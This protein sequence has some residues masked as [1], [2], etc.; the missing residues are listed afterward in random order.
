MNTNPKRKLTNRLIAMLLV[1]AM[2]CVYVVGDNYAPLATDRNKLKASNVSAQT[3]SYD[4]DLVNPTELKDV[5][6]LVLAENTTTMGK[7]SDSLSEAFAQMPSAVKNK[8]ELNEAVAAFKQQISDLK[9]KTNEELNKTDNGTDEFNEYKKAVLSGFTD[10]ESMLA[11]VSVE[12]YEQIMS[13]ISA[14]LNPK[15]P[16]VSL[17]DDLPFNEISEDNITYSDYNPEAVTDYKI[18]DGSY[19]EKDLQQTNDTVIND[20]VRAEFSEFESVLEVYQYIKNNYTMEYYFGSRKG[21]VGASAEKAGNDYDIASLLVGVL[22]D[23]NIP[24]RY[25]KGE[26]EISAEQA[27][28]WTATDDINVAMRIIAALGIP[29]TGMILNGET[30]AVRLEHI[31]VEAYVPYTDYRGTGNRSG[32]R[33]WIPLD[34]SFKEMI[35]NDGVNAEEIQDYISNPSNKITSSTEINGVNIGELADIMDADNSAF[36]KYLLEN[37]Y[38]EATLAETFGG[39]SI[40]TTDLGYLPLTLPYNN[41]DSVK[42]FEDIP[43]ELT[44]SVNFK[45]YGNSAM[46]TSYSGKDSINY[47]YYTP[48]VYGKRIVLSYVPA[49]AADQEIISEYGNIFSAPAYLIKMKPQLAIDGDVVAE[50]SICNAGYMQQYTLT[51]HNGSSSTNDSNISNNIEIGGMYCIAMDYGN[52]SPQEIQNSAEHME[53]KKDTTSE[54]NI[55]TEEIMGGM[56]NSIAKMYF[57]QL[58]LYNS[59]LSGQKNVTATRALSVGIVGFKANVVYTFNKPS[60]LTE[61]GFFLDIGHDVHSVVSNTNNSKDEKTFM[62]QSGIYASA[63]EHGVLEQVTGV[64]SVST[65]KTFQYAQEHKIPMHMVAKENLNDELDSITV[66]SQVKQE[67]RTAVNSGK[68]VII[69]E[70]EITINQWNGIGYMI[71]DTDTFA[72]GYMI[73]GGMAGGSMTAGQMIGE[74]VT[75]VIEGA[76]FMIAWEIFKTAALAMCPC[77]WTTAIGFLINMTEFVMMIEYVNQIV[78]LWNMYKSTGDIYYLQELGVQ[79]AAFATLGIASKLLGNQVNELRDA[80]NQAVDEAGLTG[81]CFVAGT[82]ISTPYGLIPI[83]N[84]KVGDTVY[85]FDGETEVVS[86][87][88]VEEVFVRETTE[89]VDIRIGTETIRSTPDHPFYVPQKGFTNAIEL[90]AGDTLLSLNGDYVIIEEIQHE[91]L[92]F[93]ITVYNFRVANDHTY[94][95]GE[96]NIGVH[97]ANYGKNAKLGNEFGH[98]YSHHGAQ[99]PARDFIGRAASSHHN[100]G[101]WLHNENAAN[102]IIT[103]KPPTEGKVALIDIPEGLGQVYTPS[104]EVVPAPRAKVVFKPD[105]TIRTAYPTLDTTP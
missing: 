1:L 84:V 8:A 56:L 53:S 80:V 21:A 98:T 4:T 33:M 36:V 55:Y 7:T 73:S 81:K 50:G 38:G 96:K 2:T 12:N 28:E 67:I 45:L 29:T 30:V 78:D 69:P 75:Y 42:T 63:M 72:C 49:S 41:T 23:R 95:V 89:L 62:L 59:V 104:G 16:Y 40:V 71:L 9:A 66:S 101:Q 99:K 57:A 25:A 6:E 11:D 26:I 43:E 64:E 44:D 76:I 94:F 24:A 83:E 47:T 27:M 100:V 86:E 37:G 14:L 65:I 90:R 60:E 54:E 87:N 3:L 20:D 15:K 93:P 18:D 82:L 17:A 77:G 58:D 105:G 68:I 39:T 70:T 22:R 48:D 34:A 61:G 97:N 13:D 5:S 79:V 19:S 92:E 46:G 31:W 102:L 51:V 103:V 35:R 88:I 74:Y 10:L 32:E 91:I 85:S 52:I